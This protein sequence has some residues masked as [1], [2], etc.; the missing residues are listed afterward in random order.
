MSGSNECFGDPAN[1]DRTDHWNIVKRIVDEN[2]A[3]ATYLSRGIL[4][5]HELSEVDDIISE[6]TGVL[7]EAIQD[8][9]R[10]VDNPEAYLLGI[11]R[12]LSR[13]KARDR[14]RGQPGEPA[15]RGPIG[16]E[17]NNPAEIIVL[18][19]SRRRRQSDVERML[20]EIE[21]LPPK[22]AEAIRL[23]AVG[24]SSGEIASALGISDDA[25]RQ[26]IA[27]AKKEL[28]KRLIQ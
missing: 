28:R 18:E 16:A 13:G 8:T 9:E 27:R 6:A 2:R 19:E 14:E 7:Y 10:Q 3:K 25:A 23:R 20:E 4:R 17:D 15:G 21:T 5:R 24:C 26:R 1:A 11:V 22:L 12:N